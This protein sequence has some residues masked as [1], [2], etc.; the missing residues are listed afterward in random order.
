MGAR[1][2]I[3]TLTGTW[4]Q[5]GARAVVRDLRSRALHRLAHL[6]TLKCMVVELGDLRDGTIFE[7]DGFEGRWANPGELAPLTADPA[8][9]LSASFLGQAA[10]RGDRCYVMV[11]GQQKVASYGWYSNASTDIDESFVLHF[12]PAYTYM[13]KGFTLPEHRGHRLHAVGMC[14]ALRALTDEG[15]KGLVSFVMANNFASL[16]STERM[17][18]RIFGDIYLLRAGSQGLAVG[19]PGCRAYGFHAEPRTGDASDSAL[20]RLGRRGLSVASTPLA[21]VLGLFS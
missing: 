4:H 21:A 3:D 5:H 2:V 1:E 15:Q 13:Y 17:G 16:K 10:A 7:A 19:T 11:D 14:R 9:D 8:Y 20:A 6:H 12:D 18:Y